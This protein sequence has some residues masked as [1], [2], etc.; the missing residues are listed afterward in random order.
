MSTARSTL[1]PAGSPARV[2]NATV[3]AHSSPS[4]GG[5]GAV[6]LT[7][8][9]R[10]VVTVALV[11]LF[12]VA[13]TWA[14]GQSAASDDVPPER[15]QATRTVLVSKGETLW[16]IAAEAAPERDIRTVIHEIQTMNALPGP[17]LVEGQ[18]LVVPVG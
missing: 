18:A 10:V 7:R 15:S 12:L 14:G 5:S 6:R 4:R 8:R 9:G 11:A 13:L 2:E 16:A 17:E 1:V 3:G